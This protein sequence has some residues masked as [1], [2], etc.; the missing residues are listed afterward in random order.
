MAVP[1]ALVQVVAERLQNNIGLKPTLMKDTL[2]IFVKNIIRGHVKIRLAAT[3][4]DT[5][6]MDVYRLLLEHTY[7]AVQSVSADKVI[8]YAQHIEGSDLW[9]KGDFRKELQH[10]ADLG[11]RMCNAILAE[12]SSGLG[13]MIVIGSDCPALQEQ[14]INDAF[15]AL[16]S[17]DIVIGP[18][19]DGGYYLIGMN[20]C[21]KALFAGIEW[22]TSR[23]LEQTRQKCAAL[24]LSC[25]LL[26]TLHDVDE[27]Q[28]LVHLKNLP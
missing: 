9:N 1:P 21:H 4:G 23:V 10:G 27:E 28:D 3:V 8:Y 15:A 18:A 16:N 22:S 25:F 14:H 20:T 13:K 19:S 24:N 2:L 5:R 17:Y 6:A 26:P 7:E 12:Q 11:D